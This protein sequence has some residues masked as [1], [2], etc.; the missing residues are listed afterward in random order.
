[1]VDRTPSGMAALVNETAVWKQ[2]IPESHHGADQAA[3][4]P[5]LS[6]DPLGEMQPDSKTEAIQH[7]WYVGTGGWIAANT[8]YLF[9][10]V[11]GSVHLPFGIHFRCLS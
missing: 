2:A 6:L 5:L 1:M 4:S 11:H 3:D 10:Q 8:S 7:Q 9:Q